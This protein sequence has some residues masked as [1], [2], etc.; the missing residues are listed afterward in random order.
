MSHEIV[1]AVYRA[2]P[3]KEAD[4]AALIDE[5]GPALRAEGLVTDRPFVVMRSRDGRTFVEVFEWVSRQAACDAHGNER[6]GALWGRMGEVAEFLTLA[7]L[8]EA[9]QTFP[10]FTPA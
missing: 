8:A 7:D 1:Q 3:G 5:H 2:K 9:T 4:L 10:H 6:I